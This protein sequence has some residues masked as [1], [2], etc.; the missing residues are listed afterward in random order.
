MAAN[1]R[2]KFESGMIVTLLA[3]PRLAEPL[4]HE[5][6]R[7]L[8]RHSPPHTHDSVAQHFADGLVLPES[9][10]LIYSAQ[11]PEESFG[12]FEQGLVF[13]THHNI[14]NITVAPYGSN[15]S[16]SQ[17]GKENGEMVRKSLS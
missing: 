11:V 3:A 9:A 12:S 16:L 2:I 7:Q 13:W 5:L 14:G 8:L 1:L 17:N 10:H 6:F 15:N 4:A